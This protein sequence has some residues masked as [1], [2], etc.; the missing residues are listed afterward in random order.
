MYKSR[1]KPE[2]KRLVFTPEFWSIV[3]YQGVFVHISALSDHF[4][5]LIQHISPFASSKWQFTAFHFSR[6]YI[7][8]Y[9]TIML[10]IG[11][12]VSAL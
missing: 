7:V 3:T 9:Y 4:C 6:I 2:R 5:G 12:K 1:G 11:L 10:R 8:S